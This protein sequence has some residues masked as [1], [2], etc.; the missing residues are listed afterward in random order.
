[1]L[2]VMSDTQRTTVYLSAADYRRLK[3]LA[4][5]QG[6][7]AAALIREAVAEYAR[8]HAPKTRPRSI[9]SVR[10]GADFATRAEELL[11]GLGDDT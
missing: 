4:D 11:E 10:A 9:G 6:R 1:M 7:S 3:A 2:Y 5:A 8:R